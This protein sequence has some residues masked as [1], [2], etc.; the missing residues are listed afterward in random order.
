MGVIVNEILA[1]EI[2]KP[3]I[4]KFKRRKAYARFKY[5]MWGHYL[6]RIKLL[7]IYYAWCIFSLNIDGL[8]L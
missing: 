2:H 8:K 7:K 1:E 5:N 3:A 6:L 4:K